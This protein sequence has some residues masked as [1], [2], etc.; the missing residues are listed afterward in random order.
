M[1]LGE[2]AARNP[3]RAEKDGARNPETS[4]SEIWSATNFR[5]A[6]VRA[7][8]DRALQVIPVVRLAGV[9]AGGAV[10]RSFELFSCPEDCDVDSGLPFHE[11]VE[12]LDPLP[13]STKP[14]HIARQHVKAKTTPQ[15]ERRPPSSIPLELDNARP[16]LERKW[17]G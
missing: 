17:A 14:E 8:E 7:D 11:R 10:V 9:L 13:N 15:R 3:G 1:P 2:R 16:G 5:S 12:V 6:R 4:A